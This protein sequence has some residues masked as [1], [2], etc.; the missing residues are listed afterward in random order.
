MSGRLQKNKHIRKQE[1]NGQKMLGP[2]RTNDVL[3][4]LNEYL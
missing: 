1:V 2:A 3:I 4:S